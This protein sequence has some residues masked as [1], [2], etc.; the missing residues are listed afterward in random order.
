MPWQ[1]EAPWQSVRENC[2]GSRCARP[3]EPYSRVKHSR[4]LAEQR[5][6]VEEPIGS[7]F[8]EHRREAIDSEYPPP[9]HALACA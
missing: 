6:L 7:A 1:L 3:V 4:Q 8:V 2:S 9:R 5:D